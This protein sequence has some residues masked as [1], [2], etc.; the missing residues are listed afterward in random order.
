MDRW[1]NSVRNRKGVALPLALFALV[2]LSGL[3]LAFLSMAGM[4]PTIA[5]NLTDVTRARYAADAGLEWAFDQLATNTNWNQTL[6]GPD[7]T[8]G[9]A[10]DG[11]L[12]SGATLPGLTAAFGTYSVTVR[13]DNQAGDTALTGCGPSGSCPAE[14]GNNVTDNNQVVIVTSTGT[15]RG[16][17]RTIQAVIRPGWD[18][19]SGLF[20]NNPR[21]DEPDFSGTTFLVSG[22]DTN[23]NGTAG[24]CGPKYG[25][26]LSHASEV[27]EVIDGLRPSPERRGRVQGLGGNPSASPPVASV[28]QINPIPPDLT[29]ESLQ[30]LGAN[31]FSRADQTLTSG[32]YTGNLTKDGTPTGPPQ[33]TVIHVASG[34]R[35]T[36]AGS[37]VGRGI[38]VVRGKLVLDGSF[39]FEGLILSWGNGEEPE[40]TIKGNA[41][42]LGG[43]VMFNDDVSKGSDFHASA[44]GQLLRSC[45]GLAYAR[46]FLPGGNARA[47][48]RSWREL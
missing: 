19:P 23:L 4:E 17:S 15:V 20:V 29:R 21:V 24:S 42:V 34:G 37:G 40:V 14:T 46:G 25:I 6:R 35:L 9:T 47:T 27:E 36:L 30:A 1:V 38:L 11:R 22:N 26:G 31:L 16:V 10:D 45:Q 5:A 41:K 28:S 32:T 7:N 8:A 2:M 18:L 48:L 43:M 13:N 3:L 44:N 12:A 39:R 33:I